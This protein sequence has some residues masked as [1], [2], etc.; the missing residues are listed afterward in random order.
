M[1]G[2]A[3]DR[4]RIYG[5]VGQINADAAIVFADDTRRCLSRPVR[6]HI[7]EP[8]IYFVDLKRVQL[9]PAVAVDRRLKAKVGRSVYIYGLWHDI[10]AIDEKNIYISLH[11]FG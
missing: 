8:P 10:A 4:G 11:F 2:G 9:A 3:F 7:A 5:R 6:K 1:A